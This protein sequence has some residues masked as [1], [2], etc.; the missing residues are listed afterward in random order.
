M[1]TSGQPLD[2]IVIGG[3]PSGLASSRELGRAGIRHVVLERGETIGNTW[4]HLYDGLILHTGKHF[5]A[6]PGLRF[7]SSTAVFP[8]RADFLSYLESY[9]RAFQLPIE[10]RADVTSVQQH[11]HGWTVALRNG[12]LL[13][14]RAVVIATGI[15]A[16]PYTPD[17]PNRTGFSGRVLHSVE[18]QRPA[19]F[20]GQRVLVVGSGN[21]AGEISAELADA[22]A[23]V[24]IAIRS[25]ARVVPREMLGIP[26]QYFGVALRRIPRR[27]L[28][29]T[30]SIVGGI[31]QSIRGAPPLPRPANLPC[32]TVP[33]IGFHL[34]ERIKA[35]SIRVT[36][37]LSDFT[38]DGVRFLD[39][40]EQPFDTVIL[41]T[42]Y[43]A[44]LGILGNQITRD[45]CGF[46][47][48]RN[49]VVSVD[50]PGLFFVG[51]NYDVSGGL[52]NIGQDARLAARFITEALRDNGRT[53]R[54]T[55]PRTNG[56]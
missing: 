42:G 45:D 5:S 29:G 44:A 48:R 50:R 35:G 22:G 4:A 23:Y 15:V 7:P 25:G 1:P 38:P 10:T 8:T 28:L 3:G 6:L 37:G 19:P 24:T 46:A 14:S 40:S 56:R 27:W 16:N 39:G 47:E 11:E 53:Y 30:M 26:I 21:S 20:T 2:A 43:R 34:T 31:F 17:L 32:A 52:Y 12:G 55:L 18:Y 51:H 36:A 49:R 13:Q 33:L 9:A 54:G 41:A